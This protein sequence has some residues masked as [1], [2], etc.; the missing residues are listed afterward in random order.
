MSIVEPGIA[1]RARS[2]R[3][4]RTPWTQ[5]RPCALLLCRRRERLVE[6]V[7]VEDACTTQLLDS[8]L[9]RRSFPSVVRAFRRLLDTEAEGL[10]RHVC[11][12]AELF[13]PLAEAGGTG[14]GR[15]SEEHRDVGP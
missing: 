15:A 2:P 6:V 10:G 13:D 7:F 11:S 12:P 4:T 9:A 3:R 14:S 1:T 5:H 8:F